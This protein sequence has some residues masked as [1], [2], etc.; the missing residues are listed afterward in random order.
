MRTD[1]SGGDDGQRIRL[2]L[3]RALVH[4]PQVLVLD[5]LT[6]GLDLRAKHQLLLV[7]R[8]L[9]Q[10]GTTLLLVT[11]QIESII[12]EISRCL[13]LREGAVVA[14]GPAAELLTDGPLSDLF[15]TPLQVFSAAGYR[16]VLPASP[17]EQA[18]AP[19]VPG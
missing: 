7:L 11:H 16:Q 1:R 9:S 17:P 12:P 14:D 6:T 8:Q 19:L 15:E 18:P 13:L 5:E 10:A 4:D 2:L 3:A